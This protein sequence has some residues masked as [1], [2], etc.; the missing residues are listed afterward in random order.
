M[1]R[2][3][4][5]SNIQVQG[6]DES[7]VLSYPNGYPADRRGQVPFIWTGVHNGQD[8]L[9]NPAA[10][11]GCPQGQLSNL[12]PH[13]AGCQQPG[14]AVARDLSERAVGPVCVLR[15]GS[16]P[17]VIGDPVTFSPGSASPTCSPGSPGCGSAC[18][19]YY[20]V[21]S[22]T[23]FP[24]D[25]WDPENPAPNEPTLPPLPG[26]TTCTGN[27]VTST[28]TMCNG[29]V[30]SPVCATTKICVAPPPPT[31]TTRPPT[32]TTTAPNPTD[33]NSPECKRCGTA[34][35]ASECPA[36]DKQCLLDECYAS[37]DC[38]LCN[39]DCEGI[40][41][42]TDP[43]S[44][45][46]KQC[47]DDLGASECPAD[48]SACLIGECAFNQNCQLCQFDCEGLFDR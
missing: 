8:C 15:G 28:S 22:P 4:L 10:H 41:D 35:G 25:R 3:I 27:Q 23:G 44:P 45:E 6:L 30:A 31:T 29:P 21:P 1:Q 48:D 20:C 36:A 24:P 26:P 39:F 7:Q 11:A 18:T 42:T 43:N 16:G 2:P 5:R 38:Q 14:S 19:G 13:G 17:S 47:A 40:F 12:V 37:S 34:L 33:P 46:C 32:T 9:V